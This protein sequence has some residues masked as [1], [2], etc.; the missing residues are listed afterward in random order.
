MIAYDVVTKFLDTKLFLQHTIVDLNSDTP[1]IVLFSQEKPLRLKKI[2]TH[3]YTHTHTHTHTHFNVVLFQ[4][5]SYSIL[6]YFYKFWISC[7]DAW[8]LNKVE[9]AAEFLFTVRRCL[10]CNATDC[11]TAFEACRKVNSVCF[12]YLHFPLR[13]GY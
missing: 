1:F 2:N 13:S 7:Q 11:F 8:K 12:N 10:Y 4:L 3:T 9:F 6:L 5:L